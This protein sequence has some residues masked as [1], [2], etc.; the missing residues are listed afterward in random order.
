[1]EPDRE[2][3]R[4]E[5]GAPDSPRRSNRARIA[6]RQFEDY[7]LYVTVEEEELMMATMGNNPAEEEEDM[8]MFWPQWLII[9]WFTMKRKR[10]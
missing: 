6:N 3:E 1:M 9:S 2:V 7:Q 10:E 8:R 4:T 5:A